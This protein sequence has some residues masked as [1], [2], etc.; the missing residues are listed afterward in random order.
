MKITDKITDTSVNAET[1]SLI[2]RR[3]KNAFT[4]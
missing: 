1:T 4:F 2:I 3:K